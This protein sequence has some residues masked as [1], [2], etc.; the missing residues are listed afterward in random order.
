M[1]LKMRKQMLSIA[2]AFVMA[3]GMVSTTAVYAEDSTTQTKT[4]GSKE[5]AQSWIDSFDTSKY[6]VQGDIQENEVSGVTTSIDTEKDPE[7]KGYYLELNS[8]TGVATYHITGGVETVTINDENEAIFYGNIQP[9]DTISYTIQIVNE[10]G[11]NYINN[12]AVHTD[13]PITL[14]NGQS[15][16]YNVHHSTLN[17]ADASYRWILAQYGLTNFDRF[18]E[19]NQ[20]DYSVVSISKDVIPADVNIKMTTSKPKA[21]ETSYNEGPYYQVGESQ[22][23]QVTRTD[24]PDY[25]GNLNVQNIL[26]YYNSQLGTNYT[27]LQEA[28]NAYFFEKCWTL[29]YSADLS[30]IQLNGSEPVS[31]TVAGKL[32]GVE[33]D[34]MYQNSHWG[35]SDQV[36]FVCPKKVEYVATVT[37]KEKP[38]VP[39][40]EKKDKEDKKNDDVKTSTATNTNIFMSLGAASIAGV[41]VLA[42]LKQKRKSK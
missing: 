35:W 3:M 8:E 29:N 9:G 11:D 28:W 13:S 10:S 27:S 2:A 21:N 40:D 31:V 38:Q 36:S 22:F 16:E 6:E 14:R 15:A 39:K 34:N 18:D 41:G 25:K 23:Y 24:N 17:N 42:L 33:A 7:G 20:Y 4:F 1:K 30:S 19:D 37:L 32:A 26:A 12:G 5:E